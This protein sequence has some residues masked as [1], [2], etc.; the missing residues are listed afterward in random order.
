MS[1]PRISHDFWKI[2]F[3]V[4]GSF[5][6]IFWLC[7]HGAQFLIISSRL[8]SSRTEIL[9]LWIWTSR[10][11]DE[12]SVVVSKVQVVN[13]WESELFCL[14]K[15]FHQRRL[16]HPDNFNLSATSW[17]NLFISRAI[18]GLQTTRRNLAQVALQ[19][20]VG[21]PFGWTW[22]PWTGKLTPWIVPPLEGLRRDRA[23]ARDTSLRETYVMSA[24]CFWI[25]R[26]I[27]AIRGG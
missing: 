5:I 6:F 21:L 2:S 14:S 23:S 17:D 24:S 19:S 13:S 12:R 10:H 1:H 26:I 11:L 9:W 4:G 27:L 3:R 8:C 7:W 15:S 18:L 22:N 20:R 16:I 25:W